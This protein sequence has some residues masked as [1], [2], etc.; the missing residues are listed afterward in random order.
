MLL[1]TREQFQ[2]IY[3]QGFE[4]VWAVLEAMQ[5]AYQSQIMALEARVKELEDRLGKDSH[6]SSKPPSSDGYQKKPVSLREQS[7]RKP[8]GQQGHKGRTL[9]FAETPDTVLLHSPSHCTGC[10]GSLAEVV[11]EEGERRQVLD[12]PPLSLLATEHR[13]LR[14]SCP[15]CGRT[16]VAAFPEGVPCGVSYGSNLKA[17]AL[18]CQNYQLLPSARITEMFSDLFGATFS[19]GTLFRCQQRAS[20]CLEEF[21]ASVRTT[22]LASPVVHFDETGLRVRGKLN[23]LHS[24]STSEATPV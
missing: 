2:P 6:N 23:W 15:H 13:A 9:S 20:S 5:H 24:A 21:L 19:E 7:G 22:L 10:G 17:F 18:Y 12:L 11:G 4:A 8:G 14:K 3:D 16:N 1:L